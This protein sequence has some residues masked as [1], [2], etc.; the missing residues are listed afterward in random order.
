MMKR[1][2]IGEAICWLLDHDPLPSRRVLLRPDSEY[3]AG[4]TE[5]TL[6]AKKNVT[7]A[8]V[9]HALYKKLLHQR[10]RAISRVGT[11]EGTQ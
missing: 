2:T 7:L 6:Q 5:G 11:R 9:V 1:F 10:V 4:V 3:A 8:R